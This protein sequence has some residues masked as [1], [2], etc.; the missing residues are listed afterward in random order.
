MPD[1]A[2]RTKFMTSLWAFGKRT[3]T[4]LEALISE[5]LASASL[6]LLECRQVSDAPHARR[7]TNSLRLNTL[8][9]KLDGLT[10]ADALRGQV[11]SMRLS[12]ALKGTTA[13]Q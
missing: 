2:R 13:D 8:L 11:V 6:E 7:T 10:Y 3:A 4:E 5:F 9:G 12:N 1:P